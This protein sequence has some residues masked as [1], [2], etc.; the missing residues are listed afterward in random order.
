ME[1]PRCRVG[2]LRRMLLFQS[3]TQ[4]AY[5]MIIILVV[6]LVLDTA[7]PFHTLESY[8]GAAVCSSLAIGVYLWKIFPHEMKVSTSELANAQQKV[9]GILTKVFREVSRTPAFVVYKEKVPDFLT[10]NEAR[11]EVATSPGTIQI[12]G[13]GITLTWTHRRLKRMAAASS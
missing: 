8:I 4:F 6:N 11:V 2:T 12:V 1:T 7:L 9:E 5:S 10:W 3:P 13:P